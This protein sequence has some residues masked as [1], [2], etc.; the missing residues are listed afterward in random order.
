M[1]GISVIISY[2][3]ESATLEKTLDLLTAQTLPPEEILLVN[4]SSTDDSFKIIQNWADRNGKKYHIR[5]RNIDEGT[6]VPGS[7]MNVGIRNASCNL[8]AFMDCGLYFDYYWLERQ[9]VYMK[10]NNSDVVS[11]VCLFSGLNLQDKTAI[12][13][14]AGYQRARPTVPSSLV[15][16]NVF[17][18]TGFFLENKRS[19]HDIDWIHKLNRENIR[20]DVNKNVVIKYMGANYAGS[21][22]DIFLK[23]IRYAEAT[24]NLYKYYNHHIYGV[25]LFLALM[26]FVKISFF[27]PWPYNDYI[28][29]HH[30]DKYWLDIAVLL[31]VLYVVLRGYLVP[32]LKSRNLKIL[33]EHPASFITLP[34]VGFIIDLGRLIG[35]VKGIFKHIFR[36]QRDY[37]SPS[38]EEHE[39]N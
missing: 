34:V 33:H 7:S 13:Q 31:V 35:Y 32:F 5:I 18:Q 6:N 25:F 9:M 19:G 1:D 20:R 39:V 24:I 38:T 22:K 12:A 11:G 17:E 15:K 29:L 23:T 10:K 36:R 4:S 37:S 3:N 27:R 8:L 2:H 16:K 21:L 28:P 30:I 14:M 26:Y